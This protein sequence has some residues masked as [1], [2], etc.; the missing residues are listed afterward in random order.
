MHWFDQY[1][2]Y[3]AFRDLKRF[4]QFKKREKHP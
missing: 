1:L 3:D 2:T 4:I